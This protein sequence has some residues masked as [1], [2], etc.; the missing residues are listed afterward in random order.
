M[1]LSDEE[2]TELEALHAEYV[3][4]GARVGICVAYGDATRDGLPAL[5]AEVRELRSRRSAWSAWGREANR[6]NVVEGSRHPHGSGMAH[7]VHDFSN[8]HLRPAEVAERFGFPVATVRDWIARRKITSVRIG[9]RTYVPIA[10]LERLVEEGT[11]H[12]R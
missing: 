8:T 11:R 6:R 4:G 9:R 5:I 12:A 3:S 1:S 2:L 10:E 7:N